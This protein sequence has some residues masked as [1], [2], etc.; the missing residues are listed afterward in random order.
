[1]KNIDLKRVYE[2][3]SV[4]NINKDYLYDSILTS[5]DFAD[6]HRNWTKP[7]KDITE[8][9]V[10]VKG[11]NHNLPFILVYENRKY[12]LKPFINDVYELEKFYQDNI[13]FKLDKIQDIYYP[14]LH[15]DLNKY[16]DF[17][18]YLK[19]CKINLI[20]H[21]FG[22]KSKKI[23]YLPLIKS[24][25]EL[26]RRYILELALNYVDRFTQVN[27][28]VPQLDSS[29][30]FLGYTSESSYI[31][32]GI[33]CDTGNA[34]SCMYVT[35]GNY[36]ATCSFITTSTDIQYK[37]YSLILANQL[38]VVKN[39]FYS[40]EYAIKFENINTIDFG[41]V[42]DSIGN[43]KNSINCVHYPVLSYKEF[44]N[45]EQLMKGI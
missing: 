4:T 43:Y 30:N 11:K 25:S 7:V 14:I 31:Q 8:C 34:V 44:K 28:K 33:D 13:L 38:A 40:P 15:K 10:E 45:K 26:G 29:L 35:L 1:M 2:L 12:K 39:L 24:N 9:L 42:E 41:I 21:F 27:L 16:P 6:V 3:L 37:P 18:S 36:S 32:V 22:D 20:S 23:S 5:L 17:R 19:T